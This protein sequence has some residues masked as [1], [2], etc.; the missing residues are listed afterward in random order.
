MQLSI[1]IFRDGGVIIDK[2]E[3]K[4]PKSGALANTLEIMEN[5]GEFHAI[6]DLISSSIVSM[7][8]IENK[9]IDNIEQIRGNCRRMSYITAEVMAI[10]IML[11][12]NKDDWVEGVYRCPR[13]RKEIITGTGENEDKRDKISDLDIVNMGENE[14]GEINPDEYNNLIHVD[15]VEPVKIMHGKT[16]NILHQIDSIDIRYPTLDDCIEGAQK[17]PARKDV[18]RQYAIYAESLMKVNNEDVK[19]KWKKTWAEYVINRLD[20]DDIGVITEALNKYGLNRYIK[21]TC[22][23]CGKEWSAPINTSNFFESGLHSA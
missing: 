7:E 23:H 8:T 14:D 1:P 17:Y 21:K 9:V 12:L 13:C 19:V 3:Y 4:K 11:L 20:P 10:K 15:L 16:D 2:A 22:R 5:Q 6:L 18:K